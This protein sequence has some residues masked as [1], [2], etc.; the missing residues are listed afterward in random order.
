VPNDELLTKSVPELDLI[1]GGHDHDYSYYYHDGQGTEHDA[2]YVKSGCDFRELSVIDI[3]SHKDTDV[4]RT[5]QFP[6]IIPLKSKGITIEC[7]KV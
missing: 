1:L 7:N 3:G 4:L 6:L 2:F 5:D